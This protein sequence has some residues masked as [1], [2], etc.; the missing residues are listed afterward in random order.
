VR[1]II[2]SKEF[3]KTPLAKQKHA[4]LMLKMAEIIY[5]I[6]LTGL[7]G[8][9]VLVWFVKDVQINSSFGYFMTLSIAG[10]L[11]GF[12]LQRKAMTIFNQ[13]VAN[14]ENSMPL[15]VATPSNATNPLA[16][17]INHGNT[18]ISINIQPEKN[19][20]Q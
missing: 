12:Y 1:N 8:S 4:E 5:R 7:L 16:I 18:H 19:N 13:P 10:I 15:P 6:I 2:C 11:L 17:Q 14:A 20:A 3:A 9:T